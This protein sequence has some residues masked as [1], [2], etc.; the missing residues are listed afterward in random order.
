MQGGWSARKKKGGSSDRPCTCLGNGLHGPLDCHYNHTQCHSTRCLQGLG[1]AC[2]TWKHSGGA[3]PAGP[4]C[5]CNFTRA[6]GIPKG[7]DDFIFEV[8]HSCTAGGPN[9]LL[10]AHHFTSVDHANTNLVLNA[11]G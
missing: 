5:S 1:Q 3:G 8:D 10:S 2:R 4:I 7:C 6:A 11:Y 9:F